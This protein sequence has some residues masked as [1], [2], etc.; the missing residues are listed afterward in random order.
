MLFLSS[1]IAGCLRITEDFFRDLQEEFRNWEATVDTQ[2]KPKSLWEELTEIREEFVEFLEK[3]L[4][5]TDV[6]VVENNEKKF[7]KGYESYGTKGIANA[8]Q[9][10][11]DK[12][13]ATIN[14]NI[15]EIEATLAQLKK[16][17]WVYKWEFGI[18]IDAIEKCGCVNFQ[19]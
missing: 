1:S 18:F 6:E 17:N 9:K 2:G 3:E 7:S 8:D 16:R 12:G 14:D 5:I 15:D 11:A 4:N 10:K 19:L 13:G